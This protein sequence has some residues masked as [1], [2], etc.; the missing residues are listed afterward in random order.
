MLKHVIVLSLSLVVGS[1]C[2]MFS[3]VQ[4]GQTVGT[5]A[6]AA[7]APGVG[8]PFGALIGTLLGIVF[9]RQVDQVTAQ[10][11]RKELSAQLGRDTP[12]LDETKQPVRPQGEPQRV[13]VDETVRDGA[14][15]A[16]HFETRHLE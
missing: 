5:I 10:R 16:G 3:P 7:A 6:G 2:A 14:V 1:G 4:L 13:W 9:Q 8:A 15:L 11:E 12:P